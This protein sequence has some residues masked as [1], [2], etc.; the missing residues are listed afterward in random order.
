MSEPVNH[1]NIDHVRALLLLSHAFSRDLPGFA[2]GTTIMMRE[3]GVPTE[4]GRKQ[5]LEELNQKRKNSDGEHRTKIIRLLEEANVHCTTETLLV[6]A[7]PQLYR[8]T[9]LYWKSIEDYLK[10]AAAIASLRD[11]IAG[12]SLIDLFMEAKPLI[13]QIEDFANPSLPFEQVLKK[14]ANGYLEAAHK[15]V[16]DTIDH[17]IGEQI[18]QINSVELREGLQVNFVA[19]QIESAMSRFEQTAEKS[20]PHLLDYAPDQTRTFQER[21]Q[22]D[23]RTICNR[24]F[25]ERC[26]AILVPEMQAEVIDQAKIEIQAE[27]EKLSISDVGLFSFTKLSARYEMTIASR[28]DAAVSKIH[29]EIVNLHEFHSLAHEVRTRISDYVLEVEAN[30][31]EKHSAYAKAESERIQ[32]EQDA[33]FVQEVARVGRE[34]AEKQLKEEKERFETLRKEIEEKSRQE[35]ELQ[36]TKTELKAVQDAQERQREAFREMN[37]KMRRQ[38]EKLTNKLAKQDRKREVKAQEQRAADAAAKEMKEKELQA[39]IEDL[40]ARNAAAVAAA[41]EMKEKEA[42]QNRIA[43]LERKESEKSCTVA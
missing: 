41:K 31:K 29:P 24:R 25:L 38:R 36:Q 3:I 13:M 8:Q 42:L 23:V 37:D 9:D 5:S 18:D 14:V 32:E 35:I 12:S 16:I 26:L 20:L 34:E 2:N 33:K 22:N 27:M 7:Q 4:R 19:K 28:F 1:Q 40:A 6:L 39:R 10:F 43:E 15:Y 21:I 17:E 11:N 30:Q